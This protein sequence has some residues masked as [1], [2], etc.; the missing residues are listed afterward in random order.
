[1]A[2]E[3]LVLSLARDRGYRNETF[4]T[5]DERGFDG[6]ANAWTAGR[7]AALLDEAE[8]SLRFDGVTQHRVNLAIYALQE[9]RRALPLE[10][11]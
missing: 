6:Y 7:I 9:L 10:Q 3:D 8:A 4:A 1:M 11:D 2:Y 5:T